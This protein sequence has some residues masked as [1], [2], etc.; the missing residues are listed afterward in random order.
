M[1]DIIEIENIIPKSYQK[2]ILDKVTSLQFPWYFNPN[3]V[4]NEDD[5]KLSNN[6][7]GFNHFVFEEQKQVSPFFD[8]IYPLYLNIIDQTSIKFNI[9]ERMR[10]NLTYPNKE[11]TLPWHMPH[12]DSMYPHYNAIYYVNDSDGDTV[13]FNETNKDYSDD[14]EFMKENNFTVKHRVTP[15]Q[16]KVVIFPGHYYHSSSFAKESKYRCVLN[17]NLGQIF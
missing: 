7:Q 5:L 1:D 13:I 6:I 11:S 12:I 9:L 3:L 10:F 14:F 8:S 4:S 2:F 15:K 17:I 16:G